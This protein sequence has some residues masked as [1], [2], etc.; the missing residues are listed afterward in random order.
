MKASIEEAIAMASRGKSLEGVI[1]EGL[2]DSQ[3]KAMDAL[4]LS[5]HGIVIPEE[6]IY[7]DDNDIA[8][9]ED[10]DAI[11]WSSEP[12]QLSFE[13][14]VTL[15]NQSPGD[16]KTAISLNIAVADTELKQWITMN[17]Q[18]VESI[19]SALLVDLYKTQKVLKE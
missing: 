18:K 3:V 11:T 9:D 1:I 10:F 8:Y 2:Q 17:R 16:D 14:K 7:Y 15:A 12:I 4:L 6:N 5:R 19:L 13:E